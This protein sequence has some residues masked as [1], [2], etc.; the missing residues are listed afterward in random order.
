MKL[1]VNGQSHEV[2][3][4]TLAA[5]LVELDFRGSWLATALNGDVVQAKERDRCWLTEGDRIEILSPMK[6]G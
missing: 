3:A 4:A 6:G 5:L 2:A 1:I